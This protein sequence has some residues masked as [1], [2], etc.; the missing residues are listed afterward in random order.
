LADIPIVIGTPAAEYLPP[1]SGGDL[2]IDGDVDGDGDSDI[3][4]D[5]SQRG[6]TLGM[7]VTATPPPATW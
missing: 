3:T 5:G 6:G 4:I 2:T 1:L 7:G